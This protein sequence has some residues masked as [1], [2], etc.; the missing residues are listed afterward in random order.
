VRAIIDVQRAV[1]S[2]SLRSCF[3]NMTQGGTLTRNKPKVRRWLPV[4]VCLLLVL[5]LLLLLGA[6]QPAAGVNAC[7]Y[8]DAV[9]KAC[10]A[11]LG[12]CYRCT[13]SK[14][15]P[16]RKICNVDIGQCIVGGVFSNFDWQE[17][18]LILLVFLAAGVSNAGGVGGGLLFVPLLVLL[19][20]FPIPQASANSQS[21]ILGASIANSVYNFRKRHVIR[22]APR[23]DWNLVI[24]TMPFFLCGTTPGY[25]LNISLPGYFTGF[26]LA[27]MLGALT[28]QSFLSGT[29]MTRR[30]WRMRREFLRQEAAGSAPLDG[31]AASKPT[32]PTAS[33]GTSV[34]QPGMQ[35]TSTAVGE[36]RL[37]I[38]SITSR[39]PGHQD[40]SARD[41]AS[42]A[43]LA[44]GTQ[45]GNVEAGAANI[46]HDVAGS[47]SSSGQ[48]HDPQLGEPS[49]RAA[50]Q[51]TLTEST[52]ANVVLASSQ[53]DV[54]PSVL[55]SN[56]TVAAAAEARGP[57]HAPEELL[58]A[59][60]AFP[61]QRRDLDPL[62]ISVLQER[63]GHAA[64]DGHLTHR[65]DRNERTAIWVGMKRSVSCQEE[66]LVGRQHRS[67]DDSTTSC[68]PMRV[69][70]RHSCSGVLRTA[71]LYEDLAG[72]YTVHV[73]EPSPRSRSKLA[74][75]ERS[76]SFADQEAGSFESTSKLYRVW[77]F[78]DPVLASRNLEEMLAA[79]RPWFPWRHILFVVILIAILFA[80]Q[81]LSGAPYARSPVGVPLCG[82][83]YWV[84]FMLQELSLFVI[85]LLTVFRNI[86]LRRLRA[87]YGYPWFE[88]DGLTD[89]R[90]DG[91]NLYVYPA[92]VLVIGAIDSWTGL[93]SSAL[94]IPYLYL[95]ARTDLVTVQSSMA[96]VNLVA[97]LAAAMV[98][99]VDGRLNISYSL[100]YGLWA[101]LGSYS[102]VFFVYYLVDR[103]QI[104]AFIILAISIA[105]FAAFAIVLYEA[106]H[107]VLAAR[108]ANA[109][110]KMVNIC[111]PTYL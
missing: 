52:G 71:S 60:G 87:A 14:D 108:A 91:M 96:I 20:S 92:F 68:L 64:V 48:Q 25:F 51:T 47:G 72:L 36:E 53:G 38:D 84:I 10:N 3:G 73:D 58:P 42:T 11:T 98:F 109:G 21:L 28:I 76:G 32:A 59:A 40:G 86:R 67:R 22:D 107:N 74:S 75:A 63:L 97:S 8:C 111:V 79:E 65:S 104:R 105:F 103:F 16:S 17:G 1:T 88:H 9:G 56:A 33:D 50:S 37:D 110:W 69:R 100:F 31:P 29:R 15:C 83:V 26:V 13:S 99:L 2:A 55:A 94:I 41:G 54:H 57:V 46:Q 30:Q 7:D 90:W 44:G 89:M 49:H 24:S 101:M 78:V 80:G 34:V 35:P 43:S 19:A 77:R 12:K 81:F 61:E 39:L 18:V 62:P 27:A 82:A 23:I 85:G 70:G 93:S 106:V 102:G 45:P 66:E 5:L 4:T 6:T 95:I